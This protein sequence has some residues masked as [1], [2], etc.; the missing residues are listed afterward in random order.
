M[1]DRWVTPC[2]KAGLGDSLQKV[3]LGVILIFLTVSARLSVTPLVYCGLGTVL[4]PNITVLSRINDWKR[5]ST[6]L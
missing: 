1:R 4:D 5:P 2:F 6:R 3:F